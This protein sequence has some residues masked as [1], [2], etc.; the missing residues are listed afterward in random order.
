MKQLIYDTITDKRSLPFNSAGTGTIVTHGVAIVGTGTLFNT[1]LQAGSYLVSL[2]QNECRRVYRQDNNTTAFLEFPFTSDLS[3]A[4][5][6]II[7]HIQMK[8]KEI[9]M[10]TA[11]NC[12]IDGKAFTGIL[13]LPKGGNSRSSRADLLEPVIVD[14]TGGSMQVEILNR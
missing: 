6:Q 2:S 13:T 9:S 10:D 12:F 1:E 14:A 7:S 5:P 4:A 8:V 11:D 3:S